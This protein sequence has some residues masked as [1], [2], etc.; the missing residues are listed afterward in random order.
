M[1]NR[2]ILITGAASGIGAATALRLV[3]PGD[4]VL[5]HTRRN[6]EKLEEVAKA[7]RAKDAKAE[8]ILRDL[9]EPGAGRDLIVACADHFGGMDILVANAGYA[10]KAPLGEA[11]GVERFDQAHGAIARSFFEMAE[12]ALPLLEASR[13]GRAIAVGAFGPHV[14]RTDLPSFPATAAAKAALEATV[15]ALALKLGPSGATANVVAPGFIEKDAGT[16]AAVSAE[17]VAELTSCIPMARRGT[18]AEVAAVIVFLSSL[19]ASYVTGQ[20]IHVNGG[21][22]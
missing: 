22:I 17:A 4:R 20:V 7:V 14:W 13:R 19:E 6:A 11:G 16:H 18:P 9:G 21:L 2:T 5:L 12:A 3:Q 15:R 10:D 8:C 1:E